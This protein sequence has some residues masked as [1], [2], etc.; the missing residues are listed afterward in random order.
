MDVAKNTSH[1]SSSVDK[2]Q[3]RSVPLSSTISAFPLFLIKYV[4]AQGT[5]TDFLMSCRLLFG[6]RGDVLA[7][8]ELTVAAASSE[9]PSS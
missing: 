9:P 4:Y 7:V 6:V 1:F 5:L 2:K 8:V 3:M